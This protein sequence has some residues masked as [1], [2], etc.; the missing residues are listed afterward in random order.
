MSEFST[1]ISYYRRWENFTRFP[2]VCL[3][4]R[5][6]NIISMCFKVLFMNGNIATLISVQ[7]TMDKSYGFGNRV[8]FVDTI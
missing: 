7:Y 3:N 4:G 1:E 6:T 8:L 5:A 2:A